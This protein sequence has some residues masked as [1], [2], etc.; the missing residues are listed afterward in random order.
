VRHEG[1]TPDHVAQQRQ[2]ARGQMLPVGTLDVPRYAVT[3]LPVVRHCAWRSEPQMTVSGRVEC[4]MRNGC[5]QDRCARSRSPHGWLDGHVN[6][7]R[8]AS[9]STS[10]T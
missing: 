10:W 3:T 7:E 8:A 9:E 6:S 2:I 4:A 1:L 5:R